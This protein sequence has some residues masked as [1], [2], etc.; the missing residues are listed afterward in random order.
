M[1]NTPAWMLDEEL[2]APCHKMEHV[3]KYYAGPQA[4]TDSMGLY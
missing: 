1:G 2:I 3:T 4:W